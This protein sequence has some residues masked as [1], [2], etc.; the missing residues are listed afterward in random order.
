MPKSEPDDC[1]DNQGPNA[2][3]DPDANIGYY[4]LYFALQ[5]I[6]RSM[7]PAIEGALKAE[8]LADPIWYEI[9][10]AAEEAGAD[11]VQMLALQRRLFV[12]QYALSRHVARMEMA[13]LIRRS[14]VPGVGRGQ[15]VHL[16]DAAK[17]LQARIW[18]VYAQKIEGAFA[19]RLTT[20][21]AYE[22]VGLMNRL[23]P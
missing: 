9:L 14:S 5:R 18:E 19:D 17:G 15:R 10:L 7:M 11:G 4:R 12:Q 23:Y 1:A 16:T 21:E 6:G 8:G 13:G 22:A 20:D 3:G 2:Y